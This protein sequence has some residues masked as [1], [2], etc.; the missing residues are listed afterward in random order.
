MFIEIGVG[1][2]AILGYV[3]RSKI[4]G[5]FSSNTV[6]VV[7]AKGSAFARVAE[8]D[9]KIIALKAVTAVKL[10][11]ALAAHNALDEVDALLG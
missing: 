7:A 3:Y 6:N 10:E 9:G 1:V 11:A 5:L 2:A 4:K 8:Q